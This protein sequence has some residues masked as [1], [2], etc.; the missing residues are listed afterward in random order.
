MS[1]ALFSP[2]IWETG[3]SPTVADDWGYEEYQPDLQKLAFPE[4]GPVAQQAEQPANAGGAFV[5]TGPGPSASTDDPSS[6]TEWVEVAGCI[7][8]LALGPDPRG[9]V[10]SVATMPG[11][12]RTLDERVVAAI[13]WLTAV[14][15]ELAFS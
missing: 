11:I 12:Y 4:G 14:Q 9:F 15:V 7:A 13:K 1:R 8:V 5:R 2:R 3:E 6:I 10:E